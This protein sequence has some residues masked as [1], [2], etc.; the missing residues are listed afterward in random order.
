MDNTNLSKYNAELSMISLIVS[1]YNFGMSSIIGPYMKFNLDGASFECSIDYGSFEYYKEIKELIVS[2]NEKVQWA[3]SYIEGHGTAESTRIDEIKTHE[4]A[5]MDVIV[6][7]DEKIVGYIVVEMNRVDESNYI[8]TVLE[9]ILFKDDNNN[10]KEV[11]L[12][13]ILEKI[14]QLLLK[15]RQELILE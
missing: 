7:V 3:P 13:F 9:S 15:Y 5:Y 12:E 2:S 1:N 4:K 8:V 10:L 6:K 11:S 14:E